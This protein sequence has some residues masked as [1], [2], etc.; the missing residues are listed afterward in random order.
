MSAKT[1][2][3]SKLELFTGSQEF[4][5]HG[6]VQRVL[7][8]EGVQYVAESAGAYWL[9]DEIATAQLAHPVRA[10]EFQVWRLAVD[11]EKSTALLTCDDGNDRVVYSKAIE[12]TDFPAPEMRMYF[13]NNTVLL[14]SEY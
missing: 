14:P 12:F 5:R 1:F 4:Y 11:Q 7:Y 10:E 8:T 3:A 2:D 9:V 6:L 13:T